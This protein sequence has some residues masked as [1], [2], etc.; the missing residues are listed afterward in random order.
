MYKVWPSGSPEGALAPNCIC[1]PLGT[2][3][4][5][6][7][8]FAI[9][10]LASGPAAVAHRSRCGHSRRCWFSPPARLAPRLGGAGL[11]SSATPRSG[12]HTQPVGGHRG[13]PGRKQRSPGAGLAWPC[14]QHLRARKVS[15]PPFQRT[16]GSRGAH[17]SE[18]SAAALAA[19][20]WAL[21][22]SPSVH[23]CGRRFSR[24]LLAPSWPF[25]VTTR[26][27]SEEPGGRRPPRLSGERS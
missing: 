27:R 9:C 3:P 4:F 8:G 23:T 20:R 18:G 22:S 10:S 26:G 13:G 17:G 21:H 1:M 15:S 24:W 2:F 12:S 5:R 19:L 6:T 25:R 7:P 11:C 16:L 14:W